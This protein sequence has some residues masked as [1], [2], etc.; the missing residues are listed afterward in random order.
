MLTTAE[1]VA[2]RAL[3]SPIDVRWIDWAQSMLT[4]GYDTPTLRILAGEL[5]PFDAWEMRPMVDQTLSE[6]GVALVYDVQDAIVQLAT[7]RSQQ[8]VGGTM[9]QAEALSELARIHVAV[10]ECLYRGAP[11]LRGVSPY[12]VTLTIILRRH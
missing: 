4:E 9:S 8:I 6:L 3:N 11:G 12:V 7:I 10:S 1:I 2:L 5:S